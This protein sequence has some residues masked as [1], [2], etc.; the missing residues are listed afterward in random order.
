LSEVARC[1]E[2]QEERGITISNPPL[3]KAA[4]N[5]LCDPEVWSPEQQHGHY[6]GLR[7]FNQT[8][9]LKGSGSLAA[10]LLV[11]YPGLAACLDSR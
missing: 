4:R 2:N 7:Q 11:S 1:R 10:G 5:G 3:L 8:L 9:F 6:S